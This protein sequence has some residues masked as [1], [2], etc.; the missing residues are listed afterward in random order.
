MN[1]I[2]A[3]QMNTTGSLQHNLQVIAELVEQAAKAGAKVVVLPE[4]CAIL[5][6][7]MSDFQE[8]LGD[9]IAQRAFSELAKQHRIWIIVGAL[10]VLESND[11]QMSSCC[12]VYDDQGA[13]V[14][15][16]HKMHLCQVNVSDCLPVTESDHYQAGDQVVTV[17]TPVGCI[18][19]SICY[20]LRFPELYRTLVAKGAEILVVPSAFLYATG[21]VHWETLLRARAIENTCY[22]VAPNQHGHHA[23]G[24]QSYGHTLILG[25][26]GEVVNQLDQGDGCVVAEIDRNYLS[27]VRH[28]MPV[29][30][31]RVL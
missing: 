3:I 7:N 14:A 26:W 4:H 29:L 11:C 22:V 16:Y 30:S 8:S 2:A 19:L 5:A 15:R 28:R 24:L 18:G 27:D 10:P 17:D 25:P 12:L 21:Q 23:N 6:G 1:L 20:D 31:N 13:M 9:G